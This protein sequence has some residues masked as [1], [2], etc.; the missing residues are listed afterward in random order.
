M[1]CGAVMV[2]TTMF[3]GQ[4][5]TAYN[6]FAPQP[7]T[8]QTISIAQT[9]QSG[10]PQPPPGPPGQAQIGPPTQQFLQA[11]RLLPGNQSTQLILQAAFPLQQQGS[12]SSAQPQ[13]QP[14]QGSF[15]SAQPQPQPQQLSA[16]R[17]DS[18]SDRS[19][20]QPQ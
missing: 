6:A 1:A 7:G 11:P 4:V 19:S 9:A 20:T 14:Q 13:P 2:P 3:M 5:V 18:L 12:F 10:P 16:H 17:T 8:A 15:S